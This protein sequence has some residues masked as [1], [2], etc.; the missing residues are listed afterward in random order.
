MTSPHLLSAR[1]SQ[2]FSQAF[3]CTV[4]CP[5]LTTALTV[6]IT[7]RIVSI[8]LL[9]SMYQESKNLSSHNCVPSTQW[10]AHSKDIFVEWGEEGKGEKG[11]GERQVKALRM[12]KI[13]PSLNFNERK[14]MH[15]SQKCAKCKFSYVF[16]WGGKKQEKKKTGFIFCFR[17]FF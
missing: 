10:T 11:T 7:H 13:K 14:W 15:N 6:P 4:C 8:R 2:P 3:P 1:L 5:S 16:V 9:N 17:L 12:L